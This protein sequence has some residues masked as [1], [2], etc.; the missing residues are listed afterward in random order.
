MYKHQHLPAAVAWKYGS[1]PNEL[2]CREGQIEKWPVSELGPVPD[3][4]ALAQLVAEYEAA[5]K[6]LTGKPEAA[7]TPVNLPKLQAWA[8]SMGY[9]P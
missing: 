6:P 4:A 7:H 9:K 2:T 1:H 3:A 5:G 8:V